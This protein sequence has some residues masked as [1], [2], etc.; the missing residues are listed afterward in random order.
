MKILKITTGMLLLSV[1]LFF[2]ACNKDDSGLSSDTTESE[3][4]SP[5]YMVADLDEMENPEITAPSESAEMDFESAETSANEANPP[6]MGKMDRPEREKSCRDKNHKEKNQKDRKG[7]KHPK[8]QDP[9][10]LPF[11]LKQLNLS[12][13]Q[14]VSVKHFLAQHCDCVSGHHMRVHAIHHEIMKRANDRR[15]DLIA[16]YKA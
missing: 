13:E 4:D 12:A 11:I 2:S 1:F 8:K 5:E 6:C 3:Y 16:A 10:S 14:K 7:K 15:H 9:R